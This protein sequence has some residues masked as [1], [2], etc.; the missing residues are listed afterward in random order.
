[1]RHLE[2]YLRSLEGKRILVLGM[3]VSNQPLLR[4]LLSHGLDVTACDKT[5]TPELRA[6]TDLGAKLRLGE[7]YLENLSADVV[8]RTP[9]MHPGRPELVRLQEQGAVLTSEM[10]AFFEVCPCRMIAVTGSDGKTTTTTL[11]SELLKQYD[12]A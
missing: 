8:F 2:E 1:M 9:G 3:G 6:F 12:S 4:L 11:I 10:E 7:H 5:D